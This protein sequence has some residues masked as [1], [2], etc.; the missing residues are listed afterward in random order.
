[1]KMTQLF[2]LEVLNTTKEEEIST[3][4]RFKSCHKH[5]TNFVWLYTNRIP[6]ATYLQYSDGLTYLGKQ[7]KSQWYFRNQAIKSYLKRLSAYGKLQA[8]S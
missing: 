5:I 4:D 1:M 2:C 7:A 3:A 6:T 8:F